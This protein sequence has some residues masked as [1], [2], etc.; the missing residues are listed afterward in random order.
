MR[1]ATVERPAHTCPADGCDRQVPYRQLACPKHWALVSTDT[2]KQ[3]YRT[4]RAGNTI[5][6]LRAITQARHEIN[7][8]LGDTA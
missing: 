7:A 8:A 6:H 5:A 4:Y 3:V 1:E 2:K